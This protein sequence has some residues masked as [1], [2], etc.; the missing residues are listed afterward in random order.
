LAHC[1]LYPLT[2]LV[3]LVCCAP[4]LHSVSSR[5]Q[6]FFFF[7]NFVR[8]VSWQLSP[9]GLSEIW[10]QVRENIAQCTYL[11]WLMA[12]ASTLHSLSSRLQVLFVFPILW[13]RWVGDRPQDDLAK[14][15]YRS[16]RTLKKIWIPALYWLQILAICQRQHQKKFRVPAI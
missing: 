1:T 10:P 8:L 4:T 3:W 9:R 15:G 16:E 14:F 5:F 13:G 7:S 2:Y 11:V 6:G 12:C